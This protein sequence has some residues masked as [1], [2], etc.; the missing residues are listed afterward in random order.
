MPFTAS[1]PALQPPAPTQSAAEDLAAVTRADFPLLADQACLGQP[2]IYLDHAATS[3]KPL[4]VLDALQ[5]Y[6][7]HDNANVHRGAHQ[8]SAR[9]TDAF[10]G[11]RDK[12]ARFV[13]AATPREIVFTRNA[14]EAINLVARSWG[15]AFL[16]PGDE[17]V[18]TVMEHHSNLVPWQ[19]LAARTGARLRHAGLTASGELDL[20]DLRAQI[21]ERTRLVSVVQISNTLGSHNPIS[22]IAQLA[23]AAGAL[24]LVD[25]CQSLPHLPVN[26]QTLGADF[27]VGSSHKLC[28]PTGMGF[29]WAREALLEAMPP[30]LGGGEMI[31]DVYLD[32]S[33]W[34]ELPHKFEAGTP[35]IGEAVGMGAAID[36]LTALGLE[37][38]H[39]WEQR[40]TAHLFQR[41][42]AIDGLRVLG[43]TPQQQ[44]DRGALASFVVEGLHAND[45]AALLDASGICI[46]SGHHCTQPLHRHYGISGSARASLS[47]TTTIEEI[48][49]FAEELASSVSFLREHG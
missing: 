2:L 4:A 15:D 40:L 31:Q 28:G 27:L 43:P 6:Y 1:A 44:P 36:Y 30:F 46:R 10:E 9:A 47:F 25:A 45:I 11:A 20:E 33:T 38:I 21:S 14:S 37:R 7:R 22:A 48:D 39:A 17:I 42:Q 19:Q 23:H 41:L 32:H 8:L 3:Q 24:L 5:R 35:A 13:G 18:L 29:L 34:A 49:R 26:V 12:T 16:R